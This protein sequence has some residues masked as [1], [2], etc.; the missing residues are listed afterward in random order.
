MSDR[1]TITPEPLPWWRRLL[2]LGRPKSAIERDLQQ[3]VAVANDYAARVAALEA[4]VQEVARPRKVGWPRGPRLERDEILGA[5]A[6]PLNSGVQA[7]VHQ[8]LDNYLQELLDQV[9]QPPGYGTGSKGE[10][11]PTM[12]PEQRLHL[13][14]GI[15]HLRLFQRQLIDL[16]AAAQKNE[17]DTEREDEQK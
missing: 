11:V 3:A 14:G 2:G 7:A 4:H 16:N 6:E 13:A 17:N 9:S 5:M 1:I 15:E 12:T 8:E 10:L